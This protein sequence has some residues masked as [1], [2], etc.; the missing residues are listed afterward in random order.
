MKRLFTI[1]AVFS[2]PTATAQNN[3][4]GWGSNSW[5]ALGNGATFGTTGTPT[6]IG[7][8]GWN[9]IDGGLGFSIGIQS[10]GTLWSWGTDYDD[11]LGNGTLGDQ[12]TPRQIS[13]DTKWETLSVGL[14]HTLAIKTDHTLWGFGNNIEG[15]LG[16]GSSTNITTPTQ[17]GAGTSDWKSVSAGNHFSLA[18]KTNGTLWGWG[19]NNYGE[20]GNGSTTDEYNPVQIGT[21]TDWKMVATG[22]YYSFGLKNDGTLWAW[23]KSSF[24]GANVKVPTQVGSSTDWKFIATLDDSHFA[25]KTDGT[26]WSW[27]D[28]IAGQLGIGTNSPTTTIT[29]VGTDKDWESVAPGTDQ[30]VMMKGN[31]TIWGVGQGLLNAL[32]T[33]TN[34]PLQ[35]GTDNSWKAISAGSVHGFAIKSGSSSIKPAAQSISVSVYPNPATESLSFS[36]SQPVME[37]HILNTIGQTIYNGKSVAIDVSNYPNG[38]YSYMIILNNGNQISGKFSKQ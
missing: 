32:P 31:H 21:G 35:I 8:A 1:V 15:G 12:T 9:A 16:N 37:I 10:D 4:Y 26:L 28:N 22:A 18:I 25:I 38:I 34:V 7:T 20:L 29:Q 5:G 19:D 33:T 13:T 11:E 23:G 2:I 6:K 30:T 36:T 14:D 3:I 17:V 27:G 24:G